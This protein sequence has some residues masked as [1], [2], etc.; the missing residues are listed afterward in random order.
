MDSFYFTIAVLAVVG[1][2]FIVPFFTS[3]RRA[4]VELNL[5]PLWQKRCSGKMGVIGIGIPSIRVALYQDFLVIAFLGQTVIPYRNVSGVSVRG[6]GSL[7]YFGVD[8]KLKDMRSGYHF[9]LN[10]RDSKDFVNIIESHLPH[11]SAQNSG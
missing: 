4:N 2:A 6:F 11:H 1:A 5:K 9:N 8:I 10:L 7:N 3:S